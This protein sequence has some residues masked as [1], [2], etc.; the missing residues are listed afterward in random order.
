M[1]MYVGG[2][3]AAAA[4]VVVVDLEGILREVQL[5]FDSI[6][7]SSFMVL[8]TLSQSVRIAPLDLLLLTE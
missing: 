3:A 6:S 1:M 2:D 5:L 4:A 8:Q 7:L